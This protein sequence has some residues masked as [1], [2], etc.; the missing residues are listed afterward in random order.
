[1]SLMMG[2][3][4]VVAGDEGEESDGLACGFREFRE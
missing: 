3:G 2:F 4:E 1:M